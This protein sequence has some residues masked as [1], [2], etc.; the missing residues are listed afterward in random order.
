M[1]N[2]LSDNNNSYIQRMNQTAESK[3]KVVEPFLGEG[4]TLLDF[5][6]G[7]SSEFIADVV[8]TGANY[9]SYDI[10]PT[11]QTTLSRMGVNVVTKQELLKRELQ[12][13]VI[14]LSSVFHEIMSYLTRQE[15]TETISMIVNSLKTGGYL[16]VRDWASPDAV[17]ESFTLK[18]VSKQSELEIL[19]WI[20]EL[21]K[22]SII[23]TVETKE[24]GS[25]VTTVKDAYEIMFHT[26]WGLKSLNRESK[27]QYNVT[28]AIMK[29]ILY[30]WK[31][32]LQLQGTYRYKDQSYLPYLQKYFELN[33]V[34]FDTKLV[35]IFQKN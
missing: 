22:N 23:D 16:V 25:I 5:G 32:C 3:F 12:F 27:E 9:Y 33:S 10:S 1:D 2:Y 17:S 28:G 35:C 11:V 21:Q 26:V 18:S 30:P 14:Y 29:W 4:V 24:D 34:P 15:R 31:D 19:T 13:D 20:Q 7:I 6:S 8:S